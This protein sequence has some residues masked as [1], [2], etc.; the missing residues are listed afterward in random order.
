MHPYPFF[1]KII[2]IIK[3][4]KIMGFMQCGYLDQQLEGLG[5]FQIAA[6]L[7]TVDP[8]PSSGQTRSCGF[9]SCLRKN[10]AAE[11]FSQVMQISNDYL[12]TCSCP[13]VWY[14]CTLFWDDITIICW[15]KLS[16]QT[17]YWSKTV[18]FSQFVSWKRNHNKYSLKKIDY[19]MNLLIAMKC[20]KGIWRQ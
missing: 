4:W 20:K 6:W 14:F 7:L 16:K 1:K 5:C 8:A 19:L 12:K 9:E 17:F 18:F 15:W 13:F 11:L 2:Q 10:L 3:E